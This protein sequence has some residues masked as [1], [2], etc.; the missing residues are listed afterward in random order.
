MTASLTAAVTAQDPL[1]TLRAYASLAPWNL[2]DLAAVASAI[3]ESSGIGPVNAAARARPTERAI[4][5]YVARG[6]VNPPEGRGT[7]ATY[8][9]RHLL[10]VLATKLRQMEGATLEKIQ[11]EFGVVAGDVVERRVASALGTALPAPDRLPLAPVAGLPRGR[12]GRAMLHWMTASESSGRDTRSR[13]CRR[14]PLGAGVELL[15]DEQHPLF[16]VHPDEA[17]VASAFRA[18][19][20]RLVR[21][22]TPE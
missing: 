6:L 13:V 3:L 12:I 8:T 19:L 20:E 9:Y 11:Q 16:R 17:A 14:V 1:S 18:L 7:A 22:S 2:R 15:V 10:Q 21:E 5:F 4:R